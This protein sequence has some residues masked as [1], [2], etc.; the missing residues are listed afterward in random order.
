MGLLPRTAARCSACGRALSVRME[1]KEIWKPPADHRRMRPVV[2][3]HALLS[4]VPECAGFFPVRARD[5]NRLKSMISGEPGRA[6]FLEKLDWAR[7]QFLAGAMREDQ[8]V[9]NALTA[10]GKKA[11]AA[12]GP[13]VPTP[14]GF[15]SDVDDT[16]RGL[17]RMVNEAR[18]KRLRPMEDGASVI[19]GQATLVGG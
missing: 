10:A 13:S 5:R 8:V 17:R 11:I 2:T 7:R 18:A 9:A 12:S 4:D 6:I 15:R 1:E 14:N 19:E 16:R 3:V